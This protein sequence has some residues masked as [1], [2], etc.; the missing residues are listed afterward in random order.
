MLINPHIW[1]ICD[2]N[3]CQ[4]QVGSMPNPLFN[5]FFTQPNFSFHMPE[6]EVLQ[7]YLG[8]AELPL[9]FKPID[10]QN[11]HQE[12]LTLQQYLGHAT[13]PLDFEPL[14]AKN[15]LQAFRALYDN[16]SHSKF[17]AQYAQ[18]QAQYTQLLKKLNEWCTKHHHLKWLQPNHPE[19]AKIPAFTL[20]EQQLFS[21]YYQNH[22]IVLLN[23]GKT[24]LEKLAILLEQPAIPL[25]YKKEVL[26]KLQNKMYLCAD[27]VVTNILLCN[28]NLQSPLDGL[29]LLKQI[30][31]TLIDECSL[32]HLNRYHHS[33]VMKYIGEEIHYATAYYNQ[34]CE[35]YGLPKR[36][37]TYADRIYLSAEQLDLFKNRLDEII[38]PHSVIHILSERL[39]PLY[40]ALN[41]SHLANIPTIVDEWNTK[42]RLFCTIRAD[43][44][45]DD[46]YEPVIISPL[47]WTTILVTHFRES[48]LSK[49]S[50]RT[51][52]EGKNNTHC[53]VDCGFAWIETNNQQLPLTPALFLNALPLKRPLKPSFALLSCFDY[54]IVQHPADLLENTLY[55]IC[56]PKHLIKNLVHWNFKS[57]LMALLTQQHV[58]ITEIDAEFKRSSTSKSPGILWDLV[59]HHQFEAFLS[60]LYTSALT[61][62]FLLA[63]ESHGTTISVQALL[64]LCE[65][66]EENP[67]F[68]HIL[69]IAK[70]KIQHYK[71][72]VTERTLWPSSITIASIKQSITPFIIYP[73]QLTHAPQNG[74]QQ[75][76]TIILLLASFNAFKIL[77]TIN[78]LNLLTAEN[79][80]TTL[81]DKLI[82]YK[83]FTLIHQLAKK[84]LLTNELIES[85]KTTLCPLLI[86]QEQYD[87]INLLITQN[88]IHA[89]F[90]E[91]EITTLIHASR[92]DI[93]ANCIIH[94][95]ITPTYLD[96]IVDPESLVT[97]L[98]HIA[99][100][101]QTHCLEKL[102][103][104]NALSVAQLSVTATY[105]PQQG[106]NI[107]WLLAEKQQFKLLK[108]LLDKSLLTSKHLSATTI[109]SS[110]T[111]LIEAGTNVVWFLVFYKQF[112]LLKA[113]KEKGLLTAEQLNAPIRSGEYQQCTP[114]QLLKTYGEAAPYQ[115]YQDATLLSP[116]HSP[117]SPSFFTPKA[118]STAHV[119]ETACG[120]PFYPKREINAGPS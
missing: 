16:E 94:E 50:I 69:P 22:S 51:I 80:S 14:N 49:R 6:P 57:S 77:Q 1:Y 37:D 82:T 84:Q 53:I 39:Y 42:Y 66:T 7:H 108:Q 110:E 24:A 93:I 104:D 58:G 19:A 113:C 17:R 62:S 11:A 44:L 63:L 55:Q 97:V 106:R 117:L 36:V 74:P 60:L 52:Y 81:I 103:S 3:L 35:S 32:L 87:L 89:T 86:A 21:N 92:A 75:N 43:W 45:V 34:V 15:K 112:E 26:W 56:D 68:P 85:H 91:L 12:F 18:L 95:K 9:Y 13:L 67:L 61:H 100:I 70:R 72:Q 71:Y 38:T 115:H 30:Q 114:L 83:Q 111:N 119:S 102:L 31:R 20:F 88:F 40:T 10:P 64:R 118:P 23:E 4:L 8:Y 47:Q 105:G 73:N 41:R 78:D 59:Y 25:A 54:L 116:L 96:L 2:S 76:K 101:G 99:N 33:I 48:F 90:S 28:D 46:L 79:L 120:F 98:W 65:T 27:G 29:S 5:T 107:P 109:F